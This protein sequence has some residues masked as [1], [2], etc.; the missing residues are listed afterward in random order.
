MTSQDHNKVIGIMHL[1]Y[2]GFN[3]LMMMLIVPMIIVM[4]G[5]IGSDP[6]LPTE[7]KTVF[8]I[9]GVF[10]ILFT[11]IFSIPP[12]LAGYAML[13]RKSWARVMGI[14]AA[15]FEA[16]SMPFG[17]ALCV[18]TLWFMFSGEGE[19]FYRDGGRMAQDWR[20]G[21]LRDASTF[22]WEAHRAQHAPL[23]EYTPPSPPDWRGQ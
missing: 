21:S 8:A 15:V 6:T 18:Y 5:P 2:G 4:L 13:K 12:L 22:D 1:I 23:R 17:T 14:I 16:M 9:F 19:N 20:R 3:A 7:L 11:L 10:L